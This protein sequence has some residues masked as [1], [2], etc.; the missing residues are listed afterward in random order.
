MDQIEVNKLLRRPVPNDALT[1]LAYHI[2]ERWI[3][4]AMMHGHLEHAEGIVND[5]RELIASTTQPAC[6]EDQAANSPNGREGDD[7]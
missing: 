6:V 1:I 2:I 5:S 7:E 4:W 3:E